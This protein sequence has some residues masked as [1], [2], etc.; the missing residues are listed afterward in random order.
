MCIAVTSIDFLKYKL[1]NMD[2]MYK[3]YC[4]KYIGTGIQWFNTLTFLFM[5]TKTSCDIV[6]GTFILWN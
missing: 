2:M 5:S 4:G 1:L 6:L 3:T